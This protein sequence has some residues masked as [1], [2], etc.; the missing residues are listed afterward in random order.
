MDYTVNVR[1]ILSS[2][3]IGTGGMDI[4]LINSCLGVAGGKSWE[5]NF[6]RSSPA[7]CKAL[8]KVVDSTIADNLN[9]EIDL[10]IR[11]KLEDKKSKSEIVSLT[12]RY[13]DGIQAGNNEVNNVRITI[14]F[15]MGW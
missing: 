4:G 9:E 15:D 6:T 11:A 14:N 13:H 2:F 12:Q 3:Y 8:M 10:T 7:V 1:S 5:K